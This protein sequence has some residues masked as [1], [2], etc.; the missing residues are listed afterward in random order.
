MLRLDISD[1][2]Y[3]YMFI[4]VALLVFN[5]LYIWSANGKKRIMERR[6]KKWKKEV[7]EAVACC[8]EEKEIPKKHQVR[9]ERKLRNINQLIAFNQAIQPDLEEK[10]VQHYLDLNHDTFQTLAVVY[11][12]KSA[13]EKAFFA[14][15]ISIYHP[16]KGREH[17][18]LAETLL[19][20]TDNSTIYCRENVLLALCAM[21]NAGAIERFFQLLNDNGLYHNPKLLADGLLTFEGD[22]EKLAMQLFEKS[23]YYNETLQV[24]IVQF[25]TRLSE[26]FC[27][28]FLKALQDEMTPLE[29][30]FTLIRYFQRFY[31]EEALP[32]LLEYVK[33]DEEENGGLAIPSCAAL[34]RYPGD[35]TVEILKS[36]LCS[37][38][39]YV[40]KNAA[41]S[42]I[43]L[44][45]EEDVLTELRRSQDRYASETLGYMMELKT[46]KEV[47]K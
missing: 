47:K 40:R 39:W 13:M 21:G 3:F 23:K 22:R 24:A 43:S 32:I 29:V 42:I 28:V 7:E 1:I 30:K 41:L 19:D 15:I 25:A 17:D 33:N 44:G 27:K 8:K 6:R 5:I 10:D 38:N 2:I 9:L 16:D 4:C 11:A 37:R 18:Q 36:A 46:Q 20:F 26:A 14:Y 35:G 12:E 34:A 45:V 31:Y